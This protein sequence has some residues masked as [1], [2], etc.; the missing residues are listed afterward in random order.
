MGLFDK[1]FCDVCGDKIGLLGNRK[2]EDGNLCGNCAKK[3][4]PFTTDRRKT[5]VEDIKQHLSYREANKQEVAR[6]SVTRQFGEDKKILIDDRQGKFIVTSSGGRWQGE[7]PDV[8]DIAQITSCS[9][10]IRE[11]QEEIKMKDSE[12]KSVS[13]N[14]PRYECYYDFYIAL[15]VNSPYF[16]EIAVKMNRNRTEYR[17]SASYRECER[18]VFEVESVLKPGSSAPQQNQ[19]AA[20]QNQSAPI[21]NAMPTGPKFCPHCGSP[22]G[23]GKFCESCGGAMQ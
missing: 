15:F 16:S 20:P 9:V 19:Y 11:I 5:T 13:Y 14:P 1:K 2:L 3:L 8:I 22:A 4:S 21:P 7:N 23:S 18:Q 12:G 6:F 10:D 17:G